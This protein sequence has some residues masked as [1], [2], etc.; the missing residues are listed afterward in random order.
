MKTE[1]E[2]RRRIKELELDE[3]IHYPPASVFSNAPL[4]I[5]QTSLTSELKALYFA[6]NEEVPEYH[7]GK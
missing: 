7:K 3:R 4:A 1:H 6:L 2:I 5:T